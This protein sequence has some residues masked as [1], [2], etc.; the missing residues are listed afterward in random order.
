MRTHLVVLPE[1]LATERLDALAHL[2]G[3]PG[4]GP[5]RVLVVCSHNAGRS[6]TAARVGDHVVLRARPRAVDRARAGFGPPR[7]ART[8][9]VS[10]AAREKSS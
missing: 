3:A 6:Q 10:I 7:R 9:E 8:W 5:P 4:S 1:H 2:E